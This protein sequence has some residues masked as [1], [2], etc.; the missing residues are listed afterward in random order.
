VT[1]EYPV[2]QRAELDDA[3][4]RIERADF[5]GNDMVVAG[6][7]EIAEFSGSIR[8]LR[9]IQHCTSPASGD[10]AVVEACAL[11]PGFLGCA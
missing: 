10:A 7:A 5:E 6:I 3:S 4:A 2:E 9:S 1:A 8:Q 11:R